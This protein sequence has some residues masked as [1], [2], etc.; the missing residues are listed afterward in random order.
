M[1]GNRVFLR[2][3]GARWLWAAVTEGGST[4]T[5]G[6]TVTVDNNYDKRW[7][8]EV[9][10]ADQIDQTSF[11]GCLECSFWRRLSPLD[12]EIHR[13][14]NNGTSRVNGTGYSELQYA[15][16][17]TARRIC[18]MHSSTLSCAA[19]SLCNASSVSNRCL[20]YSQHIFVRLS[21]VRARCVLTVDANPVLDK[22]QLAAGLLSETI[23]GR[24][25]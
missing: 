23:D 22:L 9:G 16:V 11:R 6:M 12:D 10:I 5:T 17:S 24:F 3:R 8:T 14:E 21:S 1:A 2:R 19:V 13:K 18:T 15:Q 20:S 7:S 25:G 4:T